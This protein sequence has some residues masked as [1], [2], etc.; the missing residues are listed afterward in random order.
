MGIVYNKVNDLFL[1][2][3]HDPN[4][5]ELYTFVYR[6]DVWTAEAEII[7]N[8]R[9]Y[10]PTVPNGC[11]YLPVQGGRTDTVETIKWNTTPNGITQSGTVKF[12]TLP[13]N[14]ILKTG[15]VIAAD[16]INNIPAYNII[17]PTGFVIDNIGLTVN[18]N[19]LQF[20]IVST[21]SSGTFQIT[22]R[23]SILK[24]NGVFVRYDD[25][26]NITIKDN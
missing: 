3:E 9:L 26:I 11:M 7:Q 22:I 1:N 25:T 4:D 15:D 5:K 8:N 19:A 23:I 20:R 2:I 16:G 24:A 6:P 13:Y 14:L 21:P 18:N 17:L 10:M 12:K